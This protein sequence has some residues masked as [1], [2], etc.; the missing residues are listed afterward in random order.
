MTPDASGFS[1]KDMKELLAKGATARR[2]IF[3]KDKTD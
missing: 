1:R 3:S 2:M